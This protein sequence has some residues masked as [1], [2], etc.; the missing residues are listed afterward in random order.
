MKAHP[1]K[2]RG[3]T[4]NNT[5]DKVLQ[6]TSLLREVLLSA[7]PAT[8]P[9][10]NATYVTPCKTPVAVLAESAVDLRN[11]AAQAQT[12]LLAA[13]LLPHAH[14]TAVPRIDPVME[15]GYESDV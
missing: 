14:A 6:H 4:S 15:A 1:A 7:H 11:N 8:G 10:V 13:A 2:D 5:L 3:D 12:A 9:S